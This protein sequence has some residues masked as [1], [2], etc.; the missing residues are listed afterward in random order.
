MDRVKQTR[1][2][3]KFYKQWL[4]NVLDGVHICVGILFL[5]EKIYIFYFLV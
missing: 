5:L 2:F 1:I 4:N 3:Y